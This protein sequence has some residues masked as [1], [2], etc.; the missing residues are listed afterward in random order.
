[1]K[2]F[3]QFTRGERGAIGVIASLIF[4]LFLFSF[5]YK[6][7]E[8]R[9]FDIL[10]F[11]DRVDDFTRQQARKE[12]SVQ[13]VFASRKHQGESKNS[14]KEDNPTGYFYP[15]DTTARKKNPWAPDKSYAI[16]KKEINCCDSSDLM[17]VP[18]FGQKRAREL[19]KYREKLGGF[20]SIEQF[21]EVF[22]LQKIP[23]SHLQTYFTANEALIRKININKAT[24]GEMIPHPYFDAYLTKS[25]LH[26]REKKGPFRS[27]EEV[28][29]A[30]G[31]Y[32]ELIEKLKHY[33]VF[34]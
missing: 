31:A 2:S 7:V 1:M 12:D 29:E 5:A 13:L 27:M 34:D 25:I 10:P 24:Y 9:P 21:A 32:P 33:I 3:F 4:A 17:A 18:L 14:E 30:T 8:K 22:V 16:I 19:L 23:L 28:K 11:Q 26:Y 20:Y 6:N 15:V